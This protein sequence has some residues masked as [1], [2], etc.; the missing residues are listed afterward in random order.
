MHSTIGEAT[1]VLPAPE[2]L[3]TAREQ[4]VEGTDLSIAMLLL[5]IA[6]Y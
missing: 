3:Y 6:I 4:G 1:A 2:A 5:S